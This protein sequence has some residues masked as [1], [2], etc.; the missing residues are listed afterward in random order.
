[1]KFRKLPAEHSRFT[2][3]NKEA[4]ALT[5]AIR[6]SRKWTEIARICFHG[7]RLR[8][9]LSGQL[10]LRGGRNSTGRKWDLLV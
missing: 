9:N 8:P 3:K 6:E 10:S 2:V 4:A 7:F 1:M 5:M